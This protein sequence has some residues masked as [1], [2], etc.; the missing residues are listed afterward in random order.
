MTKDTTKIDP[1]WHKNQITVFGSE[2]ES[3]KVYAKVLIDV[4]TYACEKYA[5]SAIVQ[6]RAKS[7]SSFAE[8]TI[9]KFDEH[10]DPV[11]EFTDLCGARVITQTQE[12]VDEICEFIKANFIIDEANSPY[13]RERLRD[14]EFG[15]LSVHY[16]VQLKQTGPL[17]SLISADDAKQIGDRKAEIQIRTLLQHAWAD[18][19][20]DRLYKSDFKVPQTFFRDG[21]ALA[22]AMEDADNG[23]ARFINGFDTYSGNYAAYMTK[24]KMQHEIVVQELLLQNEP[25]EKT[26]IP[27]AQ[28]I[29]GLAVAA[30]DYE[31]VIS[32]L[33]PYKDTEHPL[34]EMVQLEL[35]HALCQMNK[36]DV[37][38]QDY[39]NGQVLIQSAVNWARSELENTGPGKAKT[40]KF[41]ARALSLL[42]WSYTNIPDTAGHVLHLYQEALLKDPTDPYILLRLLEYEIHCDNLSELQIALYPSLLAAIDTCRRHADAGLE[43]S[44]AFFTMGKLHLL[45]NQLDESLDCYAKGIHLCMS[46]D[47]CIPEDA[48]HN[49]LQFLR[50]INPSKSK[51]ISQEHQWIQTML[52]LSQAVSNGNGGPNI[53]P[54]QPQLPDPK[55]SNFTPPIVIIAGGTDPSIENEMKTYE[56]Y[57]YTALKDFEGTVISG[58]TTVGIPGIVG[59]IAEELRN[60]GTKR[61]EL[62]GYLPEKLPH[63]APKDNRYDDFVFTKG[64][65]FSALEPLQN[66]I[67][68]VHSRV[69]P[70]EVRV[71]GINGGRIALFEYRL[72][73]ALGAEV[74][75]VDLSGRAVSDL[76]E[77]EDWWN[78]PN[79]LVLPQDTMTIRAFLN[80]G[81]AWTYPYPLDKLGEAIHSKYVQDNQ[82]RE[83]P[84]SMQ[85]WDN[86]REDLQESNRQQ[87][88]YAEEILREAGFGL[89]QSSGTFTDPKFTPE[90]VVMMAEMEHGRW[91]VERLRSGWK[92]GIEKDVENK[93][94]PSLVTWSELTPEIKGYDHSAISEFP[95]VFE[96]ARLEI[97]RL[98]E[99]GTSEM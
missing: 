67:D 52:Q 49:E 32:T 39:K 50:R 78:K 89:R 95:A 23:Y 92:Y 36:T 93:L 91:N 18:I 66:W 34:R 37:N 76:L 84:P 33:E 98:D 88:A 75:L 31:K 41:L 46:D 42:A 61:F 15:Y 38:G 8:K 65:D 30:G 19:T 27:V 53:P 81:K 86:L 97:F 74:G 90:D 96:K 83:I 1:V 26:K 63:N 25:T 99:S 3:Y 54:F 5:P 82:K 22:A 47:V 29:A 35:G 17:A 10:K 64:A 28:K 4:L 72:A 2:L 59:K 87:A 21:A 80:S 11:C 55:K 94:S 9:R 16:V 62:I 20:H 48:I 51:E 85:P 69:K 68:L 44:R 14:T 40:K 58:G 70:F 73:L 43:L 12:E 6:A 45:M 57:L 77:G 60:K 7:P 56:N 79:L 24:D 71:L 13:I